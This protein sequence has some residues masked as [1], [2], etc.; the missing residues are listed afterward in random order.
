[1]K[2]LAKAAMTLPQDPPPMLDSSFENKGNIPGIKSCRI[3]AK[4]GLA[5]FSGRKGRATWPRTIGVFAAEPSMESSV[6]R[7]DVAFGVN[8]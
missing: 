3:C 7:I 5:W 1:M 6:W 8:R 2:K 4:H